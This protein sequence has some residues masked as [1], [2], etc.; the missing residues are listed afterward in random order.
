MHLLGFELAQQ[1][2]SLRYT[3]KQSRVITRQPAIKGAKMTAFER[4][5]NTDGHYFTRIQ[6]GQRMFG[7]L[8]H[9]I[10]DMLK[11]MDDN[12]FCSHDCTLLWLRHLKSVCFS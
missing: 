2:R 7:D 9:G 4:K 6:F 10:I 3:A 1:D 12:F 8:Q 5:Q 11:D